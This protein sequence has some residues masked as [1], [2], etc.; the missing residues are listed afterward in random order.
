MNTATGKWG[1]DPE[2]NANSDEW[3]NDG[4]SGSSS[5]GSLYY[6]FKFY[7]DAAHDAYLNENSKI[8]IK[9]T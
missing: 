3:I 5:I 1:I 7:D 2:Y 6:Y 9:F 8:A 4:A